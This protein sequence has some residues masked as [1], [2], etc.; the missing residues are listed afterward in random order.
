M[1]IN[2]QPVFIFWTKASPLGQLPRSLVP[3][4]KWSIFEPSQNLDDHVQPQICLVAYANSWL[5]SLQSWWSD[6]ITLYC[7]SVPVSPISVHIISYVLHF[8]WEETCLSFCLFVQ[9]SGVWTWWVQA[10]GSE[11][12]GTPTLSATRIWNYRPC[13]SLDVGSKSA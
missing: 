7:H 1:W 4:E 10:L 13:E 9:T 3:G 2:K 8:C 11:P 6:N 5:S 12:P